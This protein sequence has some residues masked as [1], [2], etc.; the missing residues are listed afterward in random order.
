MLDDG[1]GIDRLQVVVVLKR[2]EQLSSETR[3]DRYGIG[4]R[5]FGWK[6]GYRCVELDGEVTNEWVVMSAWA[7]DQFGS[8]G[9]AAFV[10]VAVNDDECIVGADTSVAVA[11]AA[12]AL[13]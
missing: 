1:A 9:A 2:L 11:A 6:M 4:A 3:A 13:Q 7:T 12:V 10:A 5:T 8:L